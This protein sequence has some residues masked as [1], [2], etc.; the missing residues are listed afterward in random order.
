MKK[1]KMFNIIFTGICI[2]IG[3]ILP[4]FI[5]II[6]IS[7]PGSILL[8]MHIPVL[9]CGFISGLPYGIICG[10][11]LP[12]LSFLVTG[13]PPVFPVG[14]AMAFELATYGAL[15]AIFYQMMK[16]R[17][18]F[19]LVGAMIGGRIVLGLVNIIL[20]SFTDNVYGFTFFLTSAFVTALPGI[21][22][23]LI[24]IP[25]I[26]KAIEHAKKPILNH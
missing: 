21:I 1:R 13:M 8:P 18:F 20:Y 24:I 5:H 22:I 23:Q 9:L 15:T 14:I 10:V 4:K 7:N 3:L 6:P 25:A 17:V 16:G 2:A 12:L 26:M 11:T 19:S